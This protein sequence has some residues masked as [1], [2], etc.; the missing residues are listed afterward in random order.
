M[1]EIICYSGTTCSTRNKGR[2]ILPLK[3][4][5]E[6]YEIGCNEC[7]EMKNAAQRRGLANVVMSDEHIVE[8]CFA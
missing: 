5:I 3:E 4:A 7:E 1:S 6:E 2:Y 8:I